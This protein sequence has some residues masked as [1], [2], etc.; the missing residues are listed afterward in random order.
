MGYLGRGV[1]ENI[2]VVKGTTGT[3]IYAYAPNGLGVD[4]RMVYAATVSACIAAE[5]GR[6]IHVIAVDGLTDDGHTIESRYAALQK[7]FPK[8]E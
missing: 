7:L 2:R 3:T 1:L 5:F 4:G 6:P 8:G